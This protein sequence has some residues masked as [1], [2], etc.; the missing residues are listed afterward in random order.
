V[1]VLLSVLRRAVALFAL[2][3]LLAG[4]GG[5]FPP[6]SAP[7]STAPVAVRMTASGEIETLLVACTPA[8]ISRF[9]VIAPSDG[10]LDETDPRV[11]QVDFTPPVPDLHSV[12]LGVAPPGGAV[13]IPW[14]AAGLPGESEASY[15]VRA[16][17]EDGERWDLG[18]RPERIANGEVR[19]RERDL[20]PE[21][22]AEQSRCP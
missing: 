4:C 7:A 17:L 9:E 5:D 19:F 18:F 20:S 2:V 8:R 15:V 1:N 21:T 6:W 22:F 10:V 14:P 11:W 13:R 16:V 12:V 3:V